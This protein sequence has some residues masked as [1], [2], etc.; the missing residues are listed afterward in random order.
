MGFGLTCLEPKS[1]DTLSLTAEFTFLLDLTL[2]YPLES[3]SGGVTIVNLMGATRDAIPLIC[4]SS[5]YA[6]Q[7]FPHALAYA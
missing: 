5:M 2:A 7:G 3:E 4:Y 1:I 6:L